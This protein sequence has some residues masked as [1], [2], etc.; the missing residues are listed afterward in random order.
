MRWPL[1]PP[2]VRPVTK[3][4]M[5]EK[6]TPST[7]SQSQ[8]MRHLIITVHGILTF[9][10]WQERLEVLLDS[11]E[12]GKARTIEHYKFGFFSAFAFVVPF[13]RWL[14][15]RRFRRYLL[16]K[17]KSE[18]FSRID[19][20]AHSFGTHVVGWGL[21][22]ISERKR[23]Q[24]DTVIFAGSVLKSNFPWQRLHGTCV[25]RVLN[26]CG[27]R[28]KILLL[29]Q[30]LV[31]FTGMAGRIGFSGGTGRTF[32]NRFFDFGHGG[33]FFKD[34]QPYDG[35]MKRYWLPLLLSDRDP[36]AVEVPQMNLLNGL[37][38]TLANNLEPIKLGVWLTPIALF[39]IWV[40]GLYVDVQK[41]QSLYL[42]E[43]ADEQSA[44]GDDVTAMLIALEG[45]PSPDNPAILSL[46][47]PYVFGAILEEYGRLSSGLRGTSL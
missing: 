35:F 12:G 18:T 39:A 9:G 4:C 10:D 38:A 25:K 45:L 24:I 8:D 32:R 23:P 42:A 14:V 47:H 40:T 2:G 5:L 26:D 17:T 31:L 44:I 33:Y 20:V 11:Q 43:R 6:T 13:L 36:E 41:R 7:G 34:N 16:R 29:S 46:L 19:I 30:F 27:L 3:R 37:F 22:R 21:Y 15:V 28:D 1:T